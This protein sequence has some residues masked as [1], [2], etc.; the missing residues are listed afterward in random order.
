[1]LH[2]LG[3]HLFQEIGKCCVLKVSQRPR[4]CQCRFHEFQPCAGRTS[5]ANQPIANPL[6]TPPGGA[7]C[8]IPDSRARRSSIDSIVEVFSLC[9]L[10][11][12]PTR[13]GPTDLICSKSNVVNW[14][15]VHCE[16]WM[17]SSGNIL[18]CETVLL[19]TLGCI[20]VFSNASV[21]IQTI[22]LWFEWLHGV[23]VHQHICLKLHLRK[24]F[25]LPSISSSA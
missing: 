6:P 13:R 22:D 8:G 11:F 24:T 10:P 18:E 15:H 25:I 9:H 19:L 7:Y 4:T 3:R 21:L 16:F 5:S 12:A 14:C 1:M 17:C 23:K 2:C 20:H